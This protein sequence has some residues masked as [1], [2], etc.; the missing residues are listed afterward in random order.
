MNL[1]E[2]SYFYKSSVLVAKE[3]KVVCHKLAENAIVFD[4]NKAI[5]PHNYLTAACCL[6]DYGNI[7]MLSICLLYCTLLYFVIT[8]DLSKLQLMLQW[9]DKWFIGH[10]CLLW[11]SGLC[12]FIDVSGPGSYNYNWKPSFNLMKTEEGREGARDE[13]TLRLNIHQLTWMIFKRWT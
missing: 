3:Q 8:L 7:Y 4:I 1:R 10:F 13:D 2:S 12:V 9:V 5:H 11:A 6:Y